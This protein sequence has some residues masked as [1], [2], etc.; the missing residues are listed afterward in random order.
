[1]ST[2]NA[3]LMFVL[4]LSTY[5]VQI[6]EMIMNPPDHVQE[7]K[8]S[9]LTFLVALMKLRHH[10]FL[11]THF[12]ALNQVKASY[13]GLLHVNPVGGLRTQQTSPSSLSLT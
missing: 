5:V 7:E 8:I 6:K 13:R 11:Y 10:S 12:F 3:P 2:K 4:I 9:G 1:M